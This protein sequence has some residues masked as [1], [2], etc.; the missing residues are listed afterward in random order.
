MSIPVCRSNDPPTKLTLLMVP[1]CSLPLVV[2]RIANPW[3]PGVLVGFTRRMVIAS[4]YKFMGG[5]ETMELLW[6]KGMAAVLVPCAS[7]AA[8]TLTDFLPHPSRHCPS[9]D[10]VLEHIHAHDLAAAFYALAMW[11]MKTAGSRARAD[12]LAGA[13]LPPCRPAAIPS[14][15]D[16][17]PGPSGLDAAR[18][19]AKEVDGLPARESTQ[20]APVFN[21]SDASGQTQEELGRVLEKALGIRVEYHSAI[22]NAL[23]RMNMGEVEELADERHAEPFLAMCAGSTPPIAN[24][25]F[26]HT[27]PPPI[28]RKNRCHMD[29]SKIRNLTGWKPKYGKITVDEVKKVIDGFKKDG[30]WPNAP[31]RKSK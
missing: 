23:A 30:V 28:L 29:T 7:E 16:D 27:L 10:L 24:S 8:F 21:V 22:T 9:P 19:D 6:G 5:S 3:G 25:P 15:A 31:P 12:E 11:Q 17:E 20:R 4:I 2:A 26:S 18:W 13:P 1:V 14:G